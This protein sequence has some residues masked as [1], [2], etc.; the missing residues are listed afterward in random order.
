MPPIEGVHL[1]DILSFQLC[2]SQSS[3]TTRHKTRVYSQK[4]QIFDPKV[5]VSRALA[6]R[7][8]PTR[9]TSERWKKRGVSRVISP[10]SKHIKQMRGLGSICVHFP[11]KSFYLTLKSV[12]YTPS[13]MRG[14]G[15]PWQR[16]GAM[17]L[18]CIGVIAVI[19]CVNLFV[20]GNIFVLLHCV[21]LFKWL[22][23]CHTWLSHSCRHP[24][25]LIRFT[26]WTQPARK[27]LYMMQMSAHADARHFNDNLDTWVLWFKASDQFN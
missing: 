23:L 8:R 26:A 12:L 16:S 15:T 10:S 7:K 4:T 25:P 21:L 2:P 27:Q 24:V 18:G 22:R 20:F 13:Y 1:C 9:N 19:V 14:F 17:F 5:L 11:K 6:P 3:L